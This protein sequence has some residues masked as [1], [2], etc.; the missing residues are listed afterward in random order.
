MATPLEHFV[1]NVRNL[2]ANGSY[3]QLCD[4]LNKSSELLLK[5]VAH[6]DDVLATLD[7]QEHSLGILAILGCADASSI[8]PMW[9]LTSSPAKC[10]S[11]L[12]PAMESRS[13]SPRISLKEMT[14][15]A[16]ADLCHSYT[17]LLVDKKQ[18]MKGI[19]ILMKA[20]NKL[21]MTSTQLTSIHA[22]LC[23]L[24]LLAKCLK[25]A[26][27]YLEVDVDDVNRENGHYD[28]KHF[29]LYY[30][31]GG[32]IYASLKKYE[33]A[34]YFFEVAITTP[35]MAV[36]HIMLEAYKKY[37]LVALILHGKVPPLP[38][39][40][41]KVV[42]RF[43]KPISKPY[44]ELEM[45]CSSHSTDEVRALLTKHAE[46]FLRD[47]NVG[48][49]KQC[50][51]SQYRKNIQRLT[52]TFMT[53]SLSDMANRVKLSCPKE[54]ETYILNMI[55]DGEIFASINQKDGMVVFQDNPEK[56]NSPA[57]FKLLEDM[58][59][60]SIAL[61]EQIK[62]MDQEIMVNP[63]YVQ[64]TTGLQE[65]DIAAAATSSITS[66]KVPAYSM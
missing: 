31:Y 48:L 5:N 34:L 4:F 45:A 62:R 63:K 3:D 37:I 20:I 32:M 53:L 10:T 65:D 35:S 60:G 8:L 58:M 38:K 66:S 47:K 46:Q 11:L 1:C 15:C 16:V 7:M 39:F 41:S 23:Q 17:K 26:L 2:S 28:S 52:K 18:P 14:L 27:Q 25:P 13:A 57:M 12:V 42:N 64:K 44:H 59:K 51:A 54:A 49:V 36:S 9:I 43:I 55:D 56:F 33:R 30:Y 21:Q 40:T 19:H 61:D 22:D 29:L 50:L 6:L 24:C